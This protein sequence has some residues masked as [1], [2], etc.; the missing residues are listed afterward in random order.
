M[1]GLKHDHIEIDLTEPHRHAGRDYPPGATLTLPRSKA[2]WLIGLKR[3]R[4]R[5]AEPATAKKPTNKE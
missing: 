1:P 3:A 5:A 4:P 2:E